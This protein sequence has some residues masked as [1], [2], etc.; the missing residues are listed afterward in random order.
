MLS[1]YVNLVSYTRRFKFSQVDKC[2]I[3]EGIVPLMV[4]KWLL[5]HIR[6]R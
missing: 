4:S 6:I 5:R 1:I 2:N 3:L